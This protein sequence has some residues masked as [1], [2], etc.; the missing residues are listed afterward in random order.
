VKRSL[1]ENLSQDLFVMSLRVRGILLNY[2]TKGGEAI[3]KL[4]VG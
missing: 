3:G 2:G 1:L 4:E